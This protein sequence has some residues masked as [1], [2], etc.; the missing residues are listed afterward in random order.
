MTFSRTEASNTA[1]SC[2]SG[3]KCL[4]ASHGPSGSRDRPATRTSPENACV[5][6]MAAKRDDLPAPDRPTTATLL[7]GGRSMHT[8]RSAGSDVS[9]YWSR[10][11]AS[12]SRAPLP[13]PR[14]PPLD[15]P[16]VPL[17]ER[18]NAAQA[19]SEWRPPA[20]PMPR[21]AAASDTPSSASKAS[22][23]EPPP[24]GPT[25]L[26]QQPHAR[27]HHELGRSCGKPSAALLSSGKSMNS[28]TRSADTRASS[29][30]AK[31]R[32]THSSRLGT[33]W[34]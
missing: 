14:G 26:L 1:A 30:D 34:A 19:G 16:A 3:A 15:V 25:C 9:S 17:P 23:A 5:C 11:L 20:L 28:N 27:V 10:T 21:A 6:R 12:S 2:D 7:P 18:L 32:V 33:D 4:L 13:E 31:L 24:A 8:P 29:S 22:A